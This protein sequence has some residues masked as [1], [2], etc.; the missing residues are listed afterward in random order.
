MED[1][2][3]LPMWFSTRCIQTRPSVALCSPSYSVILGNGGVDELCDWPFLLGSQSRSSVIDYLKYKLIWTQY[4]KGCIIRLK[5]NIFWRSTATAFRLACEPISTSI[6][7][8]ESGNEDDDFLKEQQRKLWQ[9]SKGQLTPFVN[10][11]SDAAIVNIS[12][13]DG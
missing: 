7:A 6:C 10:L 4:T 5:W 8:R 3:L 11:A 13:E 2:G 12:H 1:A 9:K